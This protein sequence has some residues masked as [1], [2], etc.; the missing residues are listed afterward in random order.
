MKTAQMKVC[1]AAAMVSKR[2]KSNVE[3]LLVDPDMA[4]ENI[5]Y[6]WQLV[7]RHIWSKN[8]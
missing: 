3:E 6:R 5:P 8:M 7:C 1:N 4:E 2:K